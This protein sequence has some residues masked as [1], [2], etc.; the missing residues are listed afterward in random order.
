M[1]KEATQSNKDRGQQRTW[2]SV[3]PL[4]P[5][6]EAQKGFCIAW[7]TVLTAQL[8]QIISGIKAQLFVSLGCTAA[9]PPLVMLLTLAL[10]PYLCS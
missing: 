6:V 2:T 1:P 8:S 9:S 10:T 4:L 7:C 3:P 5:H